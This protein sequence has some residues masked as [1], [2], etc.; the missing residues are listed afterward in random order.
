METTSAMVATHLTCG[1]RMAIREVARIYGL[2]ED[3]ISIVTAKIPYYLEFRKR[4]PNLRY[5]NNGPSFAIWYLIRHGL[6]FYRKQLKSWDATGDRDSLRWGSGYISMPIKVLHLSRSLP[7]VSPLCNGRRTAQ[8][9]WDLS[10]S[11]FWE[12]AL[13]LLF[14]MPLTI[15]KMKESHLMNKHGILKR[16]CAQLSFWLG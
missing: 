10:K 16:F 14:G 8:K 6:K 9:R 12:I 13:W 7:K 2:T 4:L 1:A 15:L 5:L 3:E 11:T